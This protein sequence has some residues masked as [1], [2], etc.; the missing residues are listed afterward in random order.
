MTNKTT[1]GPLMS[2]LTLHRSHHT[3]DRPGKPENNYSKYYSTV[4]PNRGRGEGL[5]TRPLPLAFT[6][7]DTSTQA[8]RSCATGRPVPVIAGAGKAPVLS[9]ASGARTDHGQC[10]SHSAP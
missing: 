10:A 4:V 9:I 3:G 8:G 6:T 5:R 7:T 1:R 2:L